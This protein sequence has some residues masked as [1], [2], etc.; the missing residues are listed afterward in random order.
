MSRPIRDKQRLQIIRE[1]TRCNRRP[2]EIL[3]EIINR[4]SDAEPSLVSVT[5]SLYYSLNMSLEESVMINEWHVFGYG[6]MSDEKLDEELGPVIEMCLQR[7][8]NE[9]DHPDQKP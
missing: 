1:M 9:T 6:N 7:L 5:A 4:I 8:D 2:S 3:R